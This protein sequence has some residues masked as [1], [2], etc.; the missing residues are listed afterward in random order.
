LNF[1]ALFITPHP[2][3][4]LAGG[5]LPVAGVIRMNACGITCNLWFIV[6]SG[7]LPDTKKGGLS[8]RPFL[9]MFPEN[10]FYIV[11]III[12]KI[13]LKDKLRAKA[14]N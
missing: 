7:I 8:S 1:Q 9:I 14:M 2:L 5:V 13:N 4:F 11:T 6:V 3:S 12:H 10:T